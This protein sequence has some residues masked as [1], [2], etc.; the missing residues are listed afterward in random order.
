MILL[1]LMPLRSLITYAS[2]N[3][4][5][6]KTINRLPIFILVRRR[7]NYRSAQ[8]P[9]LPST[10]PADNIPPSYLLNT[11]QI[12]VPIMVQERLVADAGI[13]D[14]RRIGTG[15]VPFANPKKIAELTEGVQKQLDKTFGRHVKR[16]PKP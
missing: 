11:L 6:N 4:V 3:L 12:A 7:S 15:H 1:G 9:W 2:I 8:C 10:H 13:T 5:S 16:A 14:V